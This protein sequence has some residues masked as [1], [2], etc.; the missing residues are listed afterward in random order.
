MTVTGSP[1]PWRAKASDLRPMLAALEDAPLRDP[2]LIYEP[3]YDGIRALIEVH[4][5][6]GSGGVRIWSRLGNDKTAQFPEIIR[7]LDRFRRKLK[8]PVVLDGEIVALDEAGEPTGFQQLQNRIHVMDMAQGVMVTAVR[9]VAFIAFDV[10]RDGDMDLRP[11]PLAVRRVRLERM[12]GSAPG[13]I[14]RLSDAVLADGTALYRQAL[15]HGWEGLI[16]K[17]VQSP[18]H[19]GRR[20]AEWRKL[21]IVKQQE[22]VVG[23][24]TE[25]RRSRAYFGAL[26]LGVYD[27][28][29]LRYVGHTGTG[30]T[31]ASL[32]S[33]DTL[34]QKLERDT[35][36][37]VKRPATNERPHWVAPKLVAEVKF[38]EW[39]ADGKLRH[40]TYLGL[41]DDIDPRTI[42]REP[43]ARLH[44]TSM[45]D[46]K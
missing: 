12:F 4:P 24:W 44:E 8:A 16:A 30:F 38:T 23:G 18:Y 40:P 20:S 27:N 46:V 15:D 10:L 1:L 41:R 5:G 6:T 39:T 34:Q 17:S 14:L 36:P 45:R 2:H 19:T 32:A 13:S 7:A 42:R 11:L 21:K 28:Q 35:S 26:L 33:L 37:F 29:G 9:P 25:P 22:F 3:K 31:H 43:V